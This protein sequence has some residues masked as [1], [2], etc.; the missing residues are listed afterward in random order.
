MKWCWND[1]NAIDVCWYEVCL[2]DEL[3]EVEH[4]GVIADASSIASA[5]R[6]D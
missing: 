1:D 5:R 3:A 2:T 6:G 4:L